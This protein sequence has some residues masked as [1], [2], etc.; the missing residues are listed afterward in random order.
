[1]SALDKGQTAARI[2]PS[3]VWQ[4]RQA[5][6]RDM[7]TVLNIGD[8]ARLPWRFYGATRSILARA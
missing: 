1:M 5:Y 3:L 8:H 7:A 2:N 6:V 4:A